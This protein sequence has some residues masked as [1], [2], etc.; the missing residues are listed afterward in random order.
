MKW[1]SEINTPNENI[2]VSDA[3]DAV[4]PRVLFRMKW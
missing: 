2:G 1:Q 4:N 3:S